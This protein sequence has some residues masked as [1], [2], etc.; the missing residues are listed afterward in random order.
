VKRLTHPSEIG[1]LSDGAGRGLRWLTV[2]ASER[3]ITRAN[4]KEKERAD[5]RDPPAGRARRASGSSGRFNSGDDFVR[6]FNRWVRD[7][8]LPRQPK[9]TLSATLETVIQ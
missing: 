8:A 2:R 4:L 9:L 1:E 3:A 6:L 7:D 5:D